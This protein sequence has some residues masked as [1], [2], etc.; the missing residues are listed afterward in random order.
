MFNTV[1]SVAWKKLAISILIL[2]VNIS[3]SYRLWIFTF[4]DYLQTEWN[5][6]L[7]GHSVEQLANCSCQNVFSICITEFLHCC[8]LKSMWNIRMM[9]YVLGIPST[10]HQMHLVQA[11]FLIFRELNKGKNTL[12]YNHWN[13]QWFY[14]RLQ[15]NELITFGYAL[16]RS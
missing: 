7:D 4:C 11:N 13:Q 10:V 14:I 12:S 1:W 2:S 6:L 9:S 3:S 8:I 5:L 16:F 15:R